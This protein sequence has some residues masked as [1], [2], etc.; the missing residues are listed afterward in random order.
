MEKE[1][2]HICEVDGLHQFT[3]E[4]SENKLNEKV[5]TLKTSNSNEWKEDFR[6]VSLIKATD[7]GN[8]IKINALE[9][10]IRN[11]FEYDYSYFEY[12]YL[13]MDFIFKI[14]KDLSCKYKI[15][16]IEENGNTTLII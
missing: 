12:L 4:I 13:I 3:V 9:F 14:D 1:I 16:K 2:Y 15:S 10:N 5:Y 7:T 8:G 6:D 11:N